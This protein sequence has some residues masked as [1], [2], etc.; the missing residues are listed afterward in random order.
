MSDIH[1]GVKLLIWLLA[2][3]PAMLLRAWAFVTLWVWFVIPFGLPAVGYAHALGLSLFVSWLVHQ[4]P[5]QEP[6]PN[7]LLR[8]VMYSLLTPP[9]AVGFGWLYLQFM[10]AV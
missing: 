8:S 2:L 7:H 3:A 5:P 6:D 9:I 4:T 1:P 10:L